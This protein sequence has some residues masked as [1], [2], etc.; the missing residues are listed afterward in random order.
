[1]RCDHVIELFTRYR[2]GDLDAATRREVEAHLA[3]CAHCRDEFA[4]LDAVCASLREL[5]PEPAPATLVSD[6]RARLAARPERPRAVLLR[7]ALPAAAAA[8]LVV[9]AFGVLSPILSRPREAARM[10]PAGGMG[11][12]VDLSR[13]KPQDIEAA[14]RKATEAKAQM[15]RAARSGQLPAGAKAGEAGGGIAGVYPAPAAKQRVTRELLPP[16]GKQRGIG[17]P[18][19]PTGAKTAKEQAPPAALTAQPPADRL[20]SRPT[21]AAPAAKPALPPPLPSSAAVTLPPSPRPEPPRGRARASAPTTPT[22]EAPVREVAPL[23]TLV[24]PESE[25]RSRAAREAPAP[26]AA[27]GAETEDRRAPAFGG[28]GGTASARQS[29]VIVSAQATPTQ[30]A[31]GSLTLQLKTDQEIPDARMA[32][33]PAQPGAPET[34]VWQG[35]LNRS[36]SNNLEIRIGPSAGRPSGSP[37]ELILSGSQ[38]NR[39]TFH[40]FSPSAAGEPRSLTRIRGGL[41]EQHA[42][43]AASG[44]WASILQTTASQRNIYVLVPAGFP[45]GQA[46]PLGLDLSNESLAHALGRI[47]YELR[48]QEGAI[49]IEAAA[50]A[51]PP[52]IRPMPSATRSTPPATRRVSPGRTKRWGG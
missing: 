18:L 20:A 28:Y 22:A 35:R 14:R 12:N 29:Q 42:A 15:L 27:P 11:F 23:T 41:R 45:M 6:V 26:E 36:L 4:S 7:W 2:D 37:Q 52:A 44:T 1:M 30:R 9:V 40:L 38:L 48:P 25:T 32:L 50:G 13:V 34:P 5:R 3:A 10:A 8:A 19:A 49:T 33:R 31:S 43:R 24:L 46:A 39:Q 16:P 21:P 47:G 51:P 17:P